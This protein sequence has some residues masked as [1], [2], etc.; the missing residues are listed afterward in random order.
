MS[1]S[2][3]DEHLISSAVL[4]QGNFLTLKCDQVSLPDG[5]QGEREYVTHP[6]AV[7]IAPILPNGNLVFARQFRYPCNQVFL[8]LPAGKIDPDEDVLITGQRE[9][10]EE[11]GY[12]ANKWVKLGVQHPCIG[13][14]NEIIHIY[15]AQALSLANQQLDEGEFIEVVELSMQAISDQ[16]MQGKLTD[17]KTISTMYFLEKYL[18]Q[19]HG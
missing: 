9:L 16:I 5:S 8:E 1:D 18:A 13:Y 11:T 10:L 17:S 19:Q 14:S 7:V 4:A 2:N 15:L 12:K 6:G 3:L